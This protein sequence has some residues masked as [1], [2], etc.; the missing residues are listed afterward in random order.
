MSDYY[1][2]RKEGVVE[3]MAT[4]E[5]G[6]MSPTAVPE[7]DYA[8][9]V[10]PVP[11][12]RP[13]RLHWTGRHLDGEPVLL[14]ELPAAQDERGYERQFRGSRL[15]GLDV[16]R[17]LALIGMVVVHTLPAG[18]PVTGGR[19]LAVGVAAGN[20]SAL[21]ALLAGVGLALMSRGSRHEFG[22]SLLSQRFR[23]A[24]R[25]LLLYGAGVAVTGLFFPPVYNILPYY[26]VM[27][28]LLLP[29]LGMRKRP[30]ALWALGLAVLMPLVLHGFRL[31]QP[32]D[33]HNL[34]LPGDLAGD[35]VAVVSS[36]LFTGSYPA[37]TWIVYLL[38]GL[39]LGRLPLDRL[40]VQVGLL[41]YGALLSA[42]G[43]GM[44][45]LA[46]WFFGGWERMIATEQELAPR[47][48]AWLIR[49]GAEVQELP[50]DSLAWLTVASPHT[51]TFFALLHTTGNALLVLGAC[52]LLCRVIPN[53]L[54]VLARLG[55]MTL[56]FYTAH[57]IF[58]SS[59]LHQE[60]PHLALAAQLGVAV[61][62]AW[63]WG[64]FFR[65]GP[66]EWLVS[67]G[68]DLPVRVLQARQR[69]DARGGRRRRSRRRG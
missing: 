13:E 28:L 49:H 64:R 27:F 40:G 21:F 36:L 42:L 44:S 45:Y 23:I 4:A 63:L 47:E 48:V 56:T 12:P 31:Y 50:A 61:C 15:I 46:I 69:I 25:A 17:G 51:N 14:D 32:L 38:V 60:A 54:G 41:G 16:A 34:F 5:S 30:L 24:L 35:P 53:Y 19:A 37:A 29:F 55:G 26:A 58:L 59:L 33:V 3:N 39:L 20:A 10:R 57:L 11:G 8:P 66:L 52:L 9:G 68:S 6:M 43:K 2:I 18:D 1:P 62:F 65:Q 67:R 22:D 7:G